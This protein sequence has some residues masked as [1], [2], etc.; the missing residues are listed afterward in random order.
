MPPHT[1]LEFLYNKIFHQQIR[2]SDLEDGEEF[3]YNNQVFIKKNG[4]DEIILK[5]GIMN[6]N[7]LKLS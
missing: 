6:K 4:T 1:Y 2:F 7:N 5:N 3:E